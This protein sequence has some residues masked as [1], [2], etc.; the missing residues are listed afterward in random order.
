LIR[1]N[2]AAPGDEHI[3]QR[4]AQPFAGK[5]VPRQQSVPACLAPRARAFII[6]E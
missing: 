6:D 5:L 3:R 2:C 4:R 1:I